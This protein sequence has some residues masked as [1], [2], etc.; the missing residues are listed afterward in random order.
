M[1]RCGC[2]TFVEGVHA[3]CPFERDPASDQAFHHGP[4]GSA[5]QEPAEGGWFQNHK[6]RIQ[7][8]LADQVRRQQQ[9]RDWADRFRMQDQQ[10]RIQDDLADQVRRQQ[11]ERDWAD[12]FRMQDQQRRIQH[13]LAEQLRQTSW[14]RPGR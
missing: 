6:R 5:Y 2:G 7:D 3:R 8:D 13:D 10:R 9:E 1:R 11:Q 14:R 12:R 4:R